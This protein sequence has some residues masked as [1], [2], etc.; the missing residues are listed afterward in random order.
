MLCTVEKVIQFFL[1]FRR[2]L[3]ARLAIY[4][5]HY[6]FEAGASDDIELHHG[7]AIQLPR[8]VSMNGDIHVYGYL[9][10]GGNQQILA[11]RLGLAIDKGW[12]A[13][14]Y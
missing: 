1:L 2:Y 4:D 11:L 5:M 6:F 12:I 7:L 8:Q 3:P 9:L 10:A 13:N 14:R